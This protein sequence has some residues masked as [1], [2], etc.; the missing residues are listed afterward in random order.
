MTMTSDS[1]QAFAPRNSFWKTVVAAWNRYVRHKTTHEL[2]MLASSDNTKLRDLGV[3]P[4]ELKAGRLP[5]AQDAK[6]ELEILS[7]RR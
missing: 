4:G 3:K 6:T 5:S 1:H 7:L 2:T